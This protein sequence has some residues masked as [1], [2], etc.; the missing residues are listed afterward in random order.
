VVLALAGTF[1]RAEPAV[2]DRTVAVINGQVL[3]LSELQF[4]AQVALV[5]RGADPD[6]V[7]AL[8]RAALVSALDL[9]IAQR[10]EA[11]EAE[12]LRAF[13]IDEAE[14][15]QRLEK[16]I[17]HFQG[18]QAFE[19]FLAREEVDE[20]QLAEV[21]TREIRAEKVLDS[22]VRLRAQVSEADLHAYY[23]AH[24]AQIGVP[25]NQARTEIRDR[26]IKEKYAQLAAQEVASQR[27]AGSVRLIAPFAREAK[28]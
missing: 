13:P 6:A 3:T 18:Q 12:R 15:A 26:L 9:A 17:G 2:V 5:E 22:K 24:S 21:L 10:L 14:V 8:D 19:R 25:F 1:A 7:G 27:S 4:E 16:F 11:A 28:R 23:D 20:G